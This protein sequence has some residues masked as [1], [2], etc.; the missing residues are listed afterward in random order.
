MI[1]K[2]AAQER[3]KTFH[4]PNSS[5]E[6]I[7]RLEKLSANLSIIGQILIQAGPEWEKLQKDQKKSESR[8]YSIEQI[9]NLNPKNRLSLFNALFPGIAAYVEAA[10][11]LFDNFPYQ[12][13]YQRRPFRNPKQFS[14]KARISWLQGLPHAVGGYEH[15]D[16][17]WFASWAPHLGYWGPDTLGYLFAAA[18]Q[19][20]GKTGNEVFSILVSS[21]NGSHEIGMMGRHV[22]RGLLCS[23]RQEGWEYIE[24]LLLAAQREEGLRQVI[25]EAVDEAHPHAFRRILRV[26]VDNN[27]VRFSAMIRACTVWLG[28]PLEAANQKV[29]NNILVQIL[30]YLESTPNCEKAIQSNDAQDAFYALWTMAFDDV[31]VALPH[32]MSMSHSPGVD[33]RFAAVHFLSQTKLQEALPE[34]LRAL[35]DDDLRIPAHVLMSLN[36]WDYD[37]TL[38]AESDL[39]ERLERLLPRIKHKENN[40][41][42]I[43]WDWMPI[44]LERE[45]VVEKL[46]DCIGNRSPKRLFQYVDIMNV[47]GRDRVAR[48]LKE[49]K[50]KDRE[51][52]KMLLSFTGDASPSVREEAFKG[53]NGVALEKTDIIT[54]EDLLSRQA[55]DLRR[56]VIQLLLGLDDKRLFESIARLSEHKG[57]KMRLAALELLRECK[58]KR[59]N[60]QQVRT[61][62]LTYQQRQ[63]L[64]AAETRLLNELSAEAVENCSLENALGLMDPQNRTKAVPVKARN[65]NIKLISPAA[66]ACLKSLDT[67]VEQHRNDVIE[68]HRGNVKSTELLG[69]VQ[70]GWMLYSDNY[71]QSRDYSEFP[72]REIAEAWWESRSKDLRD[73]DGNELIR[74]KVAESLLGKSGGYYYFFQPLKKELTDDIQAHFGVHLDFSLNYE[75]I[76]SS[77]IEWLIWAHPEENETD[78]ILDALEESIGRIPYKELTALKNE[79]YGDGKVR[80]LDHRKIVYLDIARRQR[81]VH[82]SAWMDGHHARLWSVVRWLDGPMPNLPGGYATLDDALFAFQVGAATR[83][84]LFAMFMGNQKAD[85]WNFYRGRFNFLYQFS[86]RKPHPQELAQIKRFPIIK[87]IVDACRERILDVECR[88]GELSTAATGPAGNIR[89]VPGMRNLFRLLVAL[90]DS[91][92]DRGYGFGRHSDRSRVLSHLIRNSYPVEGDRAQDFAEQVRVNQIPERTLIDLAVYAPQWVDFIQNA[93]GWDHLNYAVWWLYA[94]TKD[95]QWT[96]DEMRDEWAARISERTPLTA[97]DLMDGA[98]DVAWFRKMYNEIGEERWKKLYDAALYASG[99]IG[100]TRARLFADAM[101]GRI[102]VE[103]ETERIRKKRNQDSVR[104]LGLIPLGAAKNQ[105]NEI[106]SRYEVMQEFLRTGKKFGSQR[107]ASEKLAVSIG[108]QNLARTAEYID[109]QR[110]EW[111]MEVEAIADLSSGAIK[112]KV[113]EFQIALSINDLAEPVLEFRKKDKLIKTVPSG[114][115]KNE[116]VAELLA[117]KQ[118]LDRQVNRM[119][120]SLEQAMCRGDEFTISELKTFFRHPMLKVMIEQLIFISAN[121]LGYPIRAGKALFHFEGKEIPLANADRVRIAHSLDLLESKEWHFWQRECFVAERVQPFKQVFRELYILTSNEKEEGN[122]SRRYAG[123]QVN[124]RQA[125]AL[126]GS[127]GWVADPNEGMRKTFHEAGISARV[128]FLY[129]LYTPAEVEGSTIESVAFTKRGEWKPLKLAEI[130]PLI[131]S[132]VMR[133]LDLVVSVAHAGGIDPESSTSSIEARIALI[134]ETSSLLNLS[135][136][137]LSERHVIIDGK[138]SNY[139]VNLGSGVVHKQPGGALCIIPVHAQHRGRIFLPF[140]DNDPKTAEIVSKIIL[141]ARDEQIKD[142][143]ILEQIL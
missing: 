137:K 75:G 48:V 37:E 68:I 58:Q 36:R 54:L 109:P 2:E 134:R 66:L 7:A 127:R 30:R 94:H 135:N 47:R 119:R 69:N 131:F 85:Q 51:I 143:T 128:G 28:L 53:L 21:A 72:L 61:L 132:E 29:V 103:K 42:P 142:P 25:F 79:Y 120:L 116:R 63:M 110:L 111:S 87:E 8:K 49:V 81:D 92:F 105:K 32:A 122:F 124:P 98:V 23:S 35:D 77:I 12:S 129:D 33:M 101:L 125:V 117:R 26:I 41:K 44:S 114:I 6:Q 55:Q 133:D 99:G 5:I 113:D 90:G 56:G 130:S 118:R 43:V 106:L 88:R 19:A 104:A 16:V 34:L 108:M 76:V 15:Q 96:A 140:V 93:I 80:A 73:I 24:R 121:G 97:S 123:H 52:L 13:G 11:E 112:V 45:M 27:L 9:K 20:G 83:D 50:K 17:I 10:W 65:S 89:S 14:L 86:T 64:T 141:L 60:L 95:R 3:L 126:F 59:R 57:E 138:L 46:I 1:S 39:F 71:R 136:V 62:T 100:H 107:K 139:N 91:G 74:A 84:D 102:T 67:L 82:L 22:V 115:K 78:F 38:L 4:N 18:I 70:A 40:L 31:S